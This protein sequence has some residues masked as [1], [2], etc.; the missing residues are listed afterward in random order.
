MKIKKYSRT[1]KQLQAIHR[2]FMIMY[3][4]GA[5]KTCDLFLNYY[6]EV[7]SYTWNDVYTLKCR[8]NHVIEYLKCSKGN[9]KDFK[10]EV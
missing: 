4:K 7:Y 9:Y 6:L 3:L 5:A 2:N 10:D 8:I 1:A